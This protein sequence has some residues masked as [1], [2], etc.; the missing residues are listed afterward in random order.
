MMKPYSLKVDCVTGGPRAV[1][2]IRAGEPHYS[3][4][5]MDHMMPGMDG[6]E[7]TRI[8]REEI[9]TD[10]ARNIPIIALTANAILGN[11]EM[12]LANGFQDFI[13]KPIEITKLDKSLR[14]WVRDKEK[15]REM[16]EVETEDIFLPTPD[17]TE[18]ISADIT[19]IDGIDIPK[20]LER[21]NGDKEILFDVLRSYAVNTR[22]L[23]KELDTFLSEGNLGDYA[24]VVHGIKGSS[25][26]VFALEVGKAAEALEAAAK[27]ADLTEVK[28][29]HPRFNQ[30]AIALMDCIDVAV[31]AYEDVADKPTA[32]EPDPALLAELREACRSFD[33]DGVDTIMERLEDFRYERGGE[34][35]AW[36]RDR[37][38]DMMFEEI[39]GGEWPEE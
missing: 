19:P 30:T 27:A 10:Y 7:A 21:F 20:A 8:I 17:D 5:F 15:E 37:V 4:I 34:L 38:N 23:L 18:G 9:G 36:L 39:A 12:F 32:A 31:N 29:S 6:V 22:Q 16:L 13:S 1:E 11:E 25:Y 2:L 26:G 35:V 24:I 28:K 3:A 33:M 14:L